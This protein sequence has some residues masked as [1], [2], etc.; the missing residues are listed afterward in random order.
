M[1]AYPR[2][3]D[4]TTKT[5]YVWYGLSNEFMVSIEGTGTMQPLPNSLKDDLSSRLRALVFKSLF[6]CFFCLR[7]HGKPA[8]P[9][10]LS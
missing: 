10:K 2:F 7:I 4:D 6:P 5:E 1:F 8:F 3:G 9:M